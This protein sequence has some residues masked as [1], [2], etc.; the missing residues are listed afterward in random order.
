LLTIL[1]T[2]GVDRKRM[3]NRAAYIYQIKNLDNGKIYIG[4]TSNFKSRKSNHINNLRNGTHVNRFLQNA[5][6]KHGENA[7][8][9]SILETTTIEDQYYKEQEY[10][11]DLQPY[12]PDGY[13]ISHLACIDNADPSVM[14]KTCNVCTKEFKTYSAKAKRCPECA[15]YENSNF[16]NNKEDY[17]ENSI[18]GQYIFDYIIYSC[19][20]YRGSNYD[21]ICDYFNLRW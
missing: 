1:V 17:I 16:L 20:G 14:I 11:N 8:E 10:L 21:L 6:N 12:E 3:S 4:S 7:F 18:A 19:N 5:W 13:N 9:F 2:E 15:E